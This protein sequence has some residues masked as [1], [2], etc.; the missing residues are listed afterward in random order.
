MLT[1]NHRAAARKKIIGARLGSSAPVG[2][3]ITAI[4]MAMMACS[5]WLITFAAEC[6][7][8][9]IVCTQTP[10]L[11]TKSSVTTH[12]RVISWIISPLRCAADV[13]SRLL[14]VPP[15]GKVPGASPQHRQL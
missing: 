10:A 14:V 4:A 7:L 13:G 5:E 11:K 15:A 12:R 9:M 1:A 3:A 6:R 8:A 2:Q